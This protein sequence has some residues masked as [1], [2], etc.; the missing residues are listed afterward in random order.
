[1]FIFV[2]FLSH[3]F[4][5]FNH[6]CQW[7]WHTEWNSFNSYLIWSFHC[8]VF[9]RGRNC[10]LKLFAPR[11]AITDQQGEILHWGMRPNNC[12][13]EA[14][15]NMSTNIVQIFQQTWN[16]VLDHVHVEHS[17]LHFVYKLILRGHFKENQLC[18]RVILQQF[19][20]NP[21]KLTSF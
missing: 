14:L 21:K 17:F 5:I 18:L 7:P 2:P 16:N 8:K 15:E 1:M 6:I 4:W 11:E 13:K 19:N 3:I 20:L 12:T 10:S 9:L